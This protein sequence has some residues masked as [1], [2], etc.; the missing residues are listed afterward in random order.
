M[1]LGIS[2]EVV[3][4]HRMGNWDTHWAAKR[5][6]NPRGKWVKKTGALT[7]AVSWCLADS[8]WFLVL[9]VAKEHSF[10]HDTISCNKKPLLLNFSWTS[11]MWIIYNMDKCARSFSTPRFP[12]GAVQEILNHLLCTCVCE[13]WVYHHLMARL[14]V[15]TIAQP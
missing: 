11:W 10:C 2:T 6:G 9:W 12:G 7:A 14:I 15:K 5:L 1:G 3:S 8:C 4:E 13:H